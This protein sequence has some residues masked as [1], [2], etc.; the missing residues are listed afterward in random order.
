[1]PK[2]SFKLPVALVVVGAA[3]I[4]SITGKWPVPRWSDVAITS[5]IVVSRSFHVVSD[6]LRAGETVATILGR[7]GVSGLNLNAL[8]VALSFDPTR[9]PAGMVFSVQRDG[10]T[11]EASQVEFRLNPER[12]LQFIRTS[13]GWI[14]HSVPVQWYADTSRIMASIE[15]SLFDAFDRA[16]SDLP[17]SLTERRKLTTQMASAFEGQINF[18]TN[19]HL[20]DQYAVVFE[21]LISEDGDVRI[22]RMLAG[23][24]TTADTTIQIFHHTDDDGNESYYDL[25]G[26]ASVGAFIRNP[27]EAA[28]ITSSFS[29]G[30]LHPILGKTRAHEGT[31]YG[32]ARG[33]PVRAVASGVV[34]SA[35]YSGGYGNLVEIRHDGGITTRYAHLSRVDVRAGERVSQK[36]VIGRVGSTGLATGPHLHFE[37]RVKGVAKDPTKVA[38]GGGV[39]L[40]TSEREAFKRDAGILAQL[41]PLPGKL[42]VTSL[43]A[44]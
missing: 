38:L 14:G 3:A 5:P 2:F 30:R 12:R 32:A 40:R 37:F 9:L 22:G 39:P 17:I 15:T 42:S 27:I 1:M 44:H 43:T 21:R 25:H 16:V 4:F 7:Q 34:T 24:A 41:L 18:G 31:D 36:K 11:D 26:R 35:G 23:S 19:V 28:Y 20:G 33:T 10:V 8:S 13:T 29:K 6:T